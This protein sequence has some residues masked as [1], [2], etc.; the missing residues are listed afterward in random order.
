MKKV[1]WM[2]AE[3]HRILDEMYHRTKVEN[4]AFMLVAKGKLVEAKELVETL[5]DS[6]LAIREWPGEKEN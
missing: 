2:I 3:N 5:D 6:L 4:E 1:D